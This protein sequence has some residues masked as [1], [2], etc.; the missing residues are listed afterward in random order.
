LRKT[1]RSRFLMASW[2]TKSARAISAFRRSSRWRYRSPLTSTLA[3]NGSA[4][5]DV[6]TRSV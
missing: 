2:V 6:P 5:D 4:C 1:E 3:V